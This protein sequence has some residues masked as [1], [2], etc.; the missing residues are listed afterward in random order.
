M[1]SKTTAYRLQ[2]SAATVTFCFIKISGAIYVGE[3]HSLGFSKLL[4]STLNPKSEDKKNELVIMSQ[5]SG[6]WTIPSILVTAPEPH[7]VPTIN[8]LPPL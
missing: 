6:Q 7:Y 1:K 5:Y 4:T 2:I 3:P 8:T